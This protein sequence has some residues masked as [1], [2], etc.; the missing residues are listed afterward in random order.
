ELHQRMVANRHRAPEGQGFLGVA[1]G[2]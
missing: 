1:E 2:I